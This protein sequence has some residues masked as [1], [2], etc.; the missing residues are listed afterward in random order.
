[1]NLQLNPKRI[2]LGDRKTSA[3]VLLAVT[4]HRTGERTLLGVENML[5]SIAVPEPFSLEI[6]GDATG[7][8]LMVRCQEDRVV[9][10][11]LASHY[12]QARVRPVTAEDDPLAVG[13]GEEAWAM[14]LRSGGPE[15]APLRTF[16]DQD[17]LDV[18]S[19]PL[20]AVI[21]SLS[22][23]RPG[24]RIVSRLLLRSL[25]PAWSQ[26]YLQ[27]VHQQPVAQG[28]SLTNPRQGRGRTSTRSS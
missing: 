19:D 20:L 28:Q 7:V 6:A 27:Q 14:T 5:Q 12:P 1:M 23:L 2:F 4:P 16:R 9:R 15:Y 25:G 8:S 22:N 18:G 21:G 17:L 10:Q 24:E 26:G 3:P 11:Q 13:G